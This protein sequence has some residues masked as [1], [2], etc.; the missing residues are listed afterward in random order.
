MSGIFATCNRNGQ[1]II[2]AKLDGV[3]SELSRWQPDDKGVWCNGSAAL[4]HAMLWNTPESKLERLPDTLGQLVITMDARLDNRQEL[5]DLLNIKAHPLSQVTD[6][7]LI[8]VAYERWG[9]DC[10]KYLLGDFAFV[11][12]DRSKEKIFCARDHLG[13]K[14]IYYHLTDKLFVCSNDLKT[15]EQHPDIPGD[16]CDEAVANY[17]VHSELRHPTLTFFKRITKL[18]PAHFLSV[19]AGEIRTKRYWRPEDAPRVKFEDAE[20]Y[21][22]KLRELL[23]LAVEARLRSDYPITSHLSGGLDSSTIAVIA[24]RKLGERGE[25]LLAFNWLHEPTE[26]DD[27]DHYEWANSRTIAEQEGI[28]HSYVSLS[29]EDIFRFL[30]TDSIA[31]GDSARFWYEYQIHTAA[32]EIGSRTLLS[33]WGGDELATYYGEAYYSDLLC[34]GRIFTLLKEVGQIAAKQKGNSARRLAGNLYHLVLLP[35]TPRSL[36]RFMPRNQ[37]PG[38]PSFPFVNKDFLPLVIREAKKEAVLTMQPQPTI[39]RHMLANLKNGHIQSRV[40]SWH[41]AAL[42][43]RLEYS[44]PLLD[45]RIVEFILGVPGQY[46]VDDY[47]TRYLFRQ[48]AKGLMPDSILWNNSKREKNRVDRLL[49]LMYNAC[50]MEAYTEK[51]NNRASRYVNKKKLLE[52]LENEKAHSSKKEIIENSIAMATAFSVMSSFDN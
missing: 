5:A 38:K 47:R 23:Q 34:Q 40:E 15:L 48:A 31:D 28:M 27:P 42:K 9:E 13:M 45:K 7:S 36:Y 6:S 49:T 52:I 2:E 11:I 39:R 16:I 12:W 44:Y 51:L 14:Q 29:A 8:L 21:A 4:A 19:T 17:F 46:F 24:A 35:L 22:G 26:A 37:C 10:P 18:E 41:A 50:Q 3:L 32:Q 1:P 20:T 25:K 33:G 30:R 43:N